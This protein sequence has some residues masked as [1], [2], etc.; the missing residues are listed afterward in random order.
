MT[1]VDMTERA[2]CLTFAE[3][4]WAEC[5]KDQAAPLTL[6]IE[7]A[8]AEAFEAGRKEGFDQGYMGGVGSIA[9]DV[10]RHIPPDM[11]LELYSCKAKLARVEALVASALPGDVVGAYRIRGALA[12]SVEKP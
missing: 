6:T 11:A 8:R 10:A 9:A 1:D 7:K 5:D 2:R 3:E 4:Y 12:G